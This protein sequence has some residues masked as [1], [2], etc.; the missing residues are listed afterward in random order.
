MK[1][2]MWS[3]TGKAVNMHGYLKG[4]HM[5]CCLQ[6]GRDERFDD[7]DWDPGTLATGPTPG[8]CGTCFAIVIGPRPRKPQKEQLPQKA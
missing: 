8:T 7:P 6:C 1:D 5:S 3:R 2:A 4:S